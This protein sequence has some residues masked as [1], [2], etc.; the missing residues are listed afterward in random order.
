MGPWKSQD[1]QTHQQTEGTAK[2]KAGSTY[3]AKVICYRPILKGLA[4]ISKILRV[5]EG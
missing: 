4:D 1:F 5:P 2:K 3:P